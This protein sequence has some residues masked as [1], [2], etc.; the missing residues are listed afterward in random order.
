[1]HNLGCCLLFSFQRFNSLIEETGVTKTHIA[2]CL[3]QEKKKANY[4][5]RDKENPK[6]NKNP[7]NAEEIAIIAKCLWTTPEYLTEETDDPSL[8]STDNLSTEEW[9]LINLYR[10]T[11]QVG[12]KMLMI[13]AEKYYNQF[14]LSE[15]N[16]ANT[17]S[18]SA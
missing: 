3:G 5:F 17:G 12:R 10:N 4:Y 11:E 7:F 16:N 13:D 6:K 14:P 2:I 1:M 18:V 8:P 15:K 9:T